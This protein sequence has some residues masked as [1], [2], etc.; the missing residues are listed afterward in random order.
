MKTT[1]TLISRIKEVTSAGEAYKNSNLLK[2]RKD[3]IERSFAPVYTRM[4][5]KFNDV[6]NCY[7]N[8]AKICI[9]TIDFMPI[10]ENIKS[11]KVKIL[12]DDFDKILAA[13]ISRDIDKIEAE[14]LRVWRSYISRKTASITGVLETLDKLIVGTPEK[15]K[16]DRAKSIFEDADIGSQL[17]V[18]TLEE[19]ISTYNVL[20]SKLN[21]NDSILVF[22]KLLASGKTVTL[23]DMSRETY[24]WI[25]TSGFDKKISLSVILNK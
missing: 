1:N 23:N 2:N 13:S 3:E 17:A 20:I 12:N 19:Y 14:L 9:L 22:L 10:K 6:F 8:L 11:V 16:L 4:N 5:T 25:K 7:N 24:D 18:R 21:L 15:E